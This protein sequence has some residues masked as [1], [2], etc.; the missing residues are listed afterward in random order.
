MGPA[1]VRATAA[2]SLLTLGIELVYA[3]FGW[4]PGSE[5]DAVTRVVNWF[6]YFTNF[7]NILCIVA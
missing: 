7:S 2:I 6:S 4:Y 3:V 1:R 5:P